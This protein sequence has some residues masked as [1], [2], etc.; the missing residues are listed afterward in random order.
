MSASA[1]AG[2]V[3]RNI[4]RLLATCTSD[5]ALGSGSSEVINHAEDVS[6]TARPVRDRVVAT[7]ITA[8]G[9]CE[10]APNPDFGSPLLSDIKSRSSSIF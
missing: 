4:G 1:P 5:T 10:N 6:E 9:V 8:N 7:H 3:H 2:T